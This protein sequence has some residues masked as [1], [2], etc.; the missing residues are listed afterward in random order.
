[1]HSG[2]L[3]SST[4]IKKDHDIHKIFFC[5]WCTGPIKVFVLNVFFFLYVMYWP[6]KSVCFKCFFFCMWCTGPIKVFVLNCFSVC[7]FFNFISFHF[8]FLRVRPVAFYC[9]SKQLFWYFIL[10]FD[11]D[12]LAKWIFQTRLQTPVLVRIKLDLSIFR[13][14]LN[15]LILFQD[16]NSLAC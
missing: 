7:V 8:L 3:L 4:L 13:I 2:Q 5:M 1:M 16:T 12:M 6:Y 10:L 9:Y 15:V 11:G 14:L